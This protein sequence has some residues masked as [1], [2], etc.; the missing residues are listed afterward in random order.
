[1]QPYDSNQAMQ[2][3]PQYGQL[4]IRPSF[5][6]L[7]WMLFLVSPRISVNGQVQTAKWG[8]DVYNMPPGDYEVTIWFPWLLMSRCGVATRRVQVAPGWATNLTYSAPFFIFMGGSMGMP[9]PSG[10]LPQGR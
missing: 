3:Q 6:I 8:L 1:M 9:P 10:L 5:F 4:A 7:Q 2:Q